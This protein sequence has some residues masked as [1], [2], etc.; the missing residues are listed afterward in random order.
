VA[1]AGSAD[2]AHREN[3]Q[4]GSDAQVRSEY[5]CRDRRRVNEECHEIVR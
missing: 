3:G 5:R 4:G 1:E 2:L